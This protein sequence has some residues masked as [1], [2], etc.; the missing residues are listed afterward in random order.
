[1]KIIKIPNDN[2]ESKIDDPPELLLALSLAANILFVIINIILWII[3][4][5]NS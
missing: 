5:I 3:I 1:M 4:F 2:I